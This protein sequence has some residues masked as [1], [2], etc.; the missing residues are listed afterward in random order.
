MT[1]DVHKICYPLAR[2]EAE[3]ERQIGAGQGGMLCVAFLAKGQCAVIQGDTSLLMKAHQLVLLEGACSFAPVGPC[4]LYGAVLE[5]QA[6][7]EICTGLQE[8]LLLAT[9]HCPDV[10]GA[11]YRIATSAAAALPKHQQSA[12]AY[13]L[14]CRLAQVHQ[15]REVFS[16]LVA[17]AVA[18]IRHHYAEVYGVEELAAQLGVSKSHLVRSFTGAVGISPGKYLT[19][20]RLEAAKALLMHREYNLEVVASLCGFSGAN[21]L[22]KVFKKATGQ[23]PAAWRQNN[24]P[25]EPMP[26][27][28]TRQE[29]L[30]YL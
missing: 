29:D 13:S 22:C 12:A 23:T 17:Q 19:A 28:V 8:P 26:Q 18:E 15:G 4:H 25:A 16:P 11:L 24:L 3:G 5:G 7:S 10:P 9:T 27:T 14:L 1:L 30:L 20:V 21:Y 6:A 2:F